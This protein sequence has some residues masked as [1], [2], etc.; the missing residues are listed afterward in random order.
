[1]N[2]YTISYTNINN[3]VQQKT[4]SYGN[5]TYVMPNPNAVNITFNN[6]TTTTTQTINLSGFSSVP[7]I[8]YSDNGINANDLTI[9]QTTL[10]LNPATYN[11]LL[12]LKI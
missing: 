8:F 1:M 4:D 9:T 6:Y 7:S 12:T 5:I 11:G 10:T 2:D 3:P